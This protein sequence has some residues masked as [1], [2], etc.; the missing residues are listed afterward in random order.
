MYMWFGTGTGFGATYSIGTLTSG[1]SIIGA[2]DVDADG[3]SDLLF[4]NASTSGFSY[5]IMNG[6]V[7]VRS[8]DSVVSTA[9]T[10]VSIGDYNA[11]GRLDLVWGNSSRR[12][13]MW[14]GSG[15]AFNNQQPVT[16]YA[17]GFVPVPTGSLW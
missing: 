13:F 14:F 6:A 5:W 1:W 17:S 12:L 11:D 8:S 7:R 9:Y 10:L 2:G 3:K 4:R 16:S 15:T